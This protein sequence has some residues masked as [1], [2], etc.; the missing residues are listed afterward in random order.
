MRSGAQSS[1]VFS[2]SSDLPT[3]PGAE[4][5]SATQFDAATLIEGADTRPCA[6]RR[7]SVVG[8][9][10]SLQAALEGFTP[11]HLQLSPAQSIAGRLCWHDSNS[12]GFLFDKPID[13]I[14]TLAHRL[15]NLPAERRQMPRVE[16]NQ[17]VSMRQGDVISFTRTRN[18][19]QGGAAFELSQPAA[20]GDS[21]Q[22]CFDGLR[23]IDATV[24]WSSGKLAGVEF[25]EQLSWQQ[26][27][28]W[29]R[30]AQLSPVITPR[31]A[32]EG[33]IPDRHAIF[34]DIPAR[35]REGVRWWNVRLRAITPQL[36]EFESR[37][38][39][40]PGMALWISLPH[41]GGAPA[42]VMECDYNLFLCEFRLPLRD[43]SLSLVT[44]TKAAPTPDN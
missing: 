13:V 43:S 41:V 29:L 10:L 9:T 22:L 27:M 12:A 31:L 24:K 2:L 42:I 36:V 21:V 19:S 18:I 33:L 25:E 20:V 35:V 17:T 38:P 16:L 30:A 3:T 23:P 5:A 11:T 4:A 14:F 39:L 28:P 1:T 37:A 7:L 15:A 26:L 8:A 40:Q 32:G 34:C 44:G 6:V